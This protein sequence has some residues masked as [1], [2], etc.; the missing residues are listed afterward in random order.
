MKRALRACGAALAY[1]SV[2]PVGR[3]ALN[4]APD[5]DTL[6]VLPWIGALIGALAGGSAIALRSHVSWN[7]V[8]LTMI[9]ILWLGTGAIHIDGFLDCADALFASVSS[10]RRHEILKDPRHGTFALV[11]MALL[12]LAWWTALG[13]THTTTNLQLLLLLIWSGSTVRF[14]AVANAFVFPYARVGNVTPAFTTRPNVVVFV[15]T[16]IALE[17]AAYFLTPRMLLVAPVII[18]ASLLASRWMAGRLGGGLVGDC[19]GAIITSFEPLMLIL[20]VLL[21]R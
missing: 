7:I 17:T 4:P 15:L 8:S 3:L 13:A 18:I 21:L 20:A 9:A 10:E 11:G 16:C 2:L 1:F 19:Y 14:A 6:V 5:A 12:A